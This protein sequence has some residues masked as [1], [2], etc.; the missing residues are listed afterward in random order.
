MELGDVQLCSDTAQQGEGPKGD[1]HFLRTKIRVN[2]PRVDKAH[3]SEF[4]RLNKIMYMA[5]SQTFS[6]KYSQVN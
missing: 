5:A 3:V 6:S 1:G 4:W 2:G